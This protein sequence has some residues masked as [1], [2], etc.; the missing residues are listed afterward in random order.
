MISVDKP[1]NTSAES[2][3]DDTYQTYDV[4]ILGAGLAGLGA[5][6]QLTKSNL[7]FLLLEGQPKAGGRVNTMNLISSSNVS[8]D[9]DAHLEFTQNTQH[10]RDVDDNDKSVC[11]S[12][13]FIDSGA[14]WLHGK[15]NY[16][17]DVA[18][19]HQ[20]LSDEQSEEGLGVF[21]RDD[22]VVLDEYLVKRTDFLVG[23]ILSECE[24]YAHDD[25][26]SA[27]LCNQQ[28]ASVKPTALPYPKSVNS[29]LLE[30]FQA[31]SGGI[32]DADQRLQAEQLLDW[33]IRFQVI[34]NSCLSLDDVSAKSWGMY[35]YNGESCQ[36]HYN[37]RRGFSSATEALVEEIGAQRFRF[38]MDVRQVAVNTDDEA[39]IISVRCA[40]GTVFRTKHVVC[41]FSIG[42]LKHGL[43]SDMFRPSL[44]EK[45]SR[46]IQAMG[47]ETINKLFLQFDE[48]W[49]GDWDGIQLVFKNNH[50]E[51]S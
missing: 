28:V 5:A 16:L 7:S 43:Y 41:T 18:E 40:D 11:E 47:F 35:S 46:A 48:A 17:H 26:Q 10:I 8:Q 34:D 49:W 12:P 33:H 6:L 25:H 36:A 13:T 27:D 24:K 30:R 51:V 19:R 29:Y 44:P 38:C 14:Q 21:I 22:G 45:L 3:F 42:S 32:T 50:Y 23:E 31:Y 20:L 4:L 39:G 2:V 9:S 37:F 15:C 1:E